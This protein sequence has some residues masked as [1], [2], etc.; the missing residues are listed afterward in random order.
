VTSIAA[1][2][3]ILFAIAAAS[4]FSL[5]STT[6]YWQTKHSLEERSRQYLRDEVNILRALL[7]K[8]DS[9]AAVRRE[10]ELE[11]DTLEYVQHF[12]RV[13]D[14]GMAILV[15]SKGMQRLIPAAAFPVPESAISDYGTTTHWKAP[16]GQTFLLK[17]ALAV[18]AESG[19]TVMLQVAL[20]ST[21]RQ[22]I[23]DRLKLVLIAVTLG[24][25]G[26]SAVAAAAITRRGLRPLRDI[27]ALTME[28]S[29]SQLGRRVTQ[30]HWPQELDNLAGA[31][32]LMLSRLQDSFARLAAFASN[33]AHEFR[34][35]LNNL[36]GETEVALARPRSAEELQ[37]VLESNLE[38][39]RRLA[40]IVDS[41]L[42]LARSEGGAQPPQCTD[43]ALDAELHN[44]VDYFQAMAEEQA[45]ELAVQPM[46][47]L[48]VRADATLLRRA[49]VNLLSNALRYTPAGGSI[50]VS[51]RPLPGGGAA[52]TVADTGCGV[53]PADIPR[54]CD[55]FYRVEAARA[56]RPGYGLGLSIVKSIMDL[57]GGTIDIQS[58]KGAGTSVTLSFPA[59][60]TPR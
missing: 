20:N 35:P 57:H 9:L 23:I 5:A 7:A 51:A 29:A 38:E 14:L 43:L 56:E 42:F 33:M 11:T 34:T 3:V 22:A 30:Q 8:P 16:D 47:P 37:Q 1:R 36:M 46:P 13:T 59:G 26:A 39:Y 17:A 52:V 18:A 15:E 49:V 12:V 27:T 10:I 21:R 25:A 19:E 40:Q 28:I 32:D 24:S 60:G 45:V 48:V 50:V 54:L 53:D 2:L 44:L 58:T 55:R 31:F 6:I 41:L 4:I